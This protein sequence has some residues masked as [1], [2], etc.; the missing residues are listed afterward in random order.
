M[1]SRNVG[2]ILIAVVISIAAVVMVTNTGE[3]ASDRTFPL[4]IT[5]DDKTYLPADEAEAVF[6]NA[7]DHRLP[8]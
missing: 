5:E 7:I 2:I 1:K 4:P 8:I 6:G 3:D